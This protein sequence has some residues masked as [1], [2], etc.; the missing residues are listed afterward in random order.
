MLEPNNLDDTCYWEIEKVDED[1][2][3]IKAQCEN[4]IILFEHLDFYK[5]DAIIRIRTDFVN[6]LMGILNQ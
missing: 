1:N 2:Y 5:A 6:R 4:G 3:S